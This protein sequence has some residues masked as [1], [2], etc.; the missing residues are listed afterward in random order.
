MPSKRWK[1]ATWSNRKSIW[2][3]E[4]HIHSPGLGRLS[5]LAVHRSE[6]P[7]EDPRV[8]Q[9]C[10]SEPAR[11]HWQAGTPATGTQRILVTPNHR[12]TQDGLSAGG[13]G[14]DP[15]STPLS[16]QEMMPVQVGMAGPGTGDPLDE[17]TLPERVCRVAG[18]RIEPPSTRHEPT[19]R[20]FAPP[21]PRHHPRHHG[22]RQPGFQH[23]RPACSGG[24]PMAITL[25]PL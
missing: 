9:G 6:N 17:L 11:G 23:P 4:S 7:Q 8:D 12:R 1:K 25:V 19:H 20:M 3:R 10:A 13:V 22:A 16:L 15:D 18:N 21:I 24:L 5:T 2:T 14:I